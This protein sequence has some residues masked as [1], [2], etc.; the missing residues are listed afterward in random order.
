MKR[1]TNP[2]FLSTLPSFHPSILLTS[3]LLAIV[4][5]LF[6]FTTLLH[7][8][9]ELSTVEAKIDRPHTGELLSDKVDLFGL[10]RGTMF[11]EYRLEYTPISTDK[12]KTVSTGWRQIG[13]RATAPVAETGF[14]GQWDVQ[15]LR[16]EFLIRLVVVSTQG[17]EAQD[18][19]R[20]FIENEHPRLEIS[21]PSEDL[22]TLEKQITVRGT[23]EKSN[24]VILKSEQMEKS[25]PVDSGGALSHSC[26]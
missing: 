6:S 20:I 14:L 13:G 5:W 12:K 9:P 3:T 1:K 23:T 19:I 26:R 15:R 24:T 11:K 4:L 17:D 18:Q 25:L 7:A 10:A 21:N 22:L 2:S 8:S 16:G